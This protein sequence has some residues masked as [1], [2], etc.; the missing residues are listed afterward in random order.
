METSLL[1][2][3]LIGAPYFIIGLAF[4]FNSKYYQK[5][6]KEIVESPAFLF[7][8]GVVAII[9][10]IVIILFHNVWD[11][12]WPLIIT[13]FGWIAFLKG[14]FLLLFPRIAAKFAKKHLE[15]RGIIIFGGLVALIVGFILVYFGFF[16]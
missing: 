4:I 14:I 2:A 10:G 3:K 12:T 11:F 16:V 5:I 1:L 7:A 8:G 13:I 9:L 6:Y 15:K